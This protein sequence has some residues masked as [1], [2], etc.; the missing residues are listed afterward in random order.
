MGYLNICAILLCFGVSL[1]CCQNVPSL[2]W[3]FDPYSTDQWFKQKLDHYDAGSIQYWPQR[4]VTSYRFYRLGGPVF[5]YLSGPGPE[6]SV[7]DVESGAIAAYAEE[8]GAFVIGLEHRYYGKSKPTQDLSTD[9]LKYLTVPQTIEDIASFIRSW[10]ARSEFRNSKL[11]MFGASYLGSVT[12]WFAQKHPELLDAFVSSSAPLELRYEIPEF[13]QSIGTILNQTDP[14]CYETVQEGFSCLENV[15]SEQGCENYT[16]GDI[17]TK[18]DLCAELDTSNAVDVTGIFAELFS[19]VSAVVMYHNPDPTSFPD[20]NLGRFCK[21]ITAE[22]DKTALEKIGEKVKEINKNRGLSCSEFRFQTTV[23]FLDDKDW[24][25]PAA[26]EGYRQ[27]QFQL[28]NEL[29]WTV[30]SANISQ[31]FGHFLSPF[32]HS[33]VCKKLFGFTETEMRLKVLQANN[34]L[35]GKALST[36]CGIY[37]NGDHDPWHTFS[38][39]RQE[40]AG[41]CNRAILIQGGSHGRDIEEFADNPSYPSEVREAQLKIARYLDIWLKTGKCCEDTSESRNVISTHSRSTRAPNSME[42]YSSANDMLKPNVQIRPHAYPHENM[43]KMIAS[44]TSI[45]YQVSTTDVLSVS[46]RIPI[47]SQDQYENSDMF[48]DP[49]NIELRRYRVVKLLR[50]RPS[51][52]PPTYER[53][54][55]P[56]MEQFEAD[57]PE[58]RLRVEGRVERVFKNGTKIDGSTQTS[59]QI[60]S[61]RSDIESQ[62]PLEQERKLMVDETDAKEAQT[63]DSMNTNNEGGLQNNNHRFR[64]VVK[65]IFRNVEDVENTKEP[66][67]EEQ[68]TD[69]NVEDT[70]MEVKESQESDIGQKNAEVSLSPKQTTKRQQD[71]KNIDITILKQIVEKNKEDSSTSDTDSH[72]RSSEIKKRE[73]SEENNE[74][75]SGSTEENY[76][77]LGSESEENSSATLKPISSKKTSDE[78]SSDEIVVKVYTKP[79]VK[80]NSKSKVQEDTKEEENDDDYYEDDDYDDDDDE[81]EESNETDGSKEDVGRASSRKSRNDTTKSNSSTELSSGEDG[82]PRRLRE[83]ISEKIMSSSE[84]FEGAQK[85]KEKDSSSKKSKNE[86]QN[87]HK[88]DERTND[89]E[90]YEDLEASSSSSSESTSD[91]DYD[92]YSLE[93]SGSNTQ[94]VYRKKQLAPIAKAAIEQ[95]ATVINVEISGSY[96]RRTHRRKTKKITKIIDVSDEESKYTVAEKGTKKPRRIRIHRRKRPSKAK[97]VINEDPSTTEGLPS[98]TP[99]TTSTTSTSSTAA[100]ATS[101]EKT[102]P[103]EMPGSNNYAA[104]N[105]LHKQVV[106]SEAKPLQQEPPTII[107]LDTG[108]SV[109]QG[110]ESSPQ[111]QNN[112]GVTYIIIGDIPDENGN[113]IGEN[114]SNDA[115]F[116]FIQKLV[117]RHSAGIFS[118]Q[119]PSTN[120]LPAPVLPPPPPP[121]PPTTTTTTTQAPPHFQNGFQPAGKYL[122]VRPVQVVPL[123]REQVVHAHDLRNDSFVDF[124]TMETPHNNHPY[125]DLTPQRSYPYQTQSIKRQNS[126]QY[127]GYRFKSPFHREHFEKLLSVDGQ[128]RDIDRDADSRRVYQHNVRR[129]DQI[130]D[131]SW[132]SIRGISQFGPLPNTGTTGGLLSLTAADTRWVNEGV[133]FLPRNR[134]FRTAHRSGGFN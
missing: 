45:P 115:L 64:Y 27:L 10:K 22:N 123:G 12:A 107:N 15:I 34:D 21:H 120:Y 79:A 52:A 122:L 1:V 68:V 13:L 28:C 106:E 118:H 75:S 19:T 46:P 91:E 131:P 133:P 109:S 61:P 6:L 78:S 7:D 16:L 126:D 112:D 58:H 33:E 85:S 2:D 32:L 20:T 50:H 44:P 47:S 105:K 127:G 71:L 17:K 9:N 90:S 65:Q 98:T 101:I 134:Q 70:S 43:E 62:Q 130:P 81:D 87:R 40:E 110:F 121:P 77:L 128:V 5:I 49:R 102:F 24:D 14:K 57:F 83:K 4:Y 67:V 55:T 39:S 42:F 36:Q 116:D 88:E 51:F 99:T 56:S 89:N 18:F 74:K 11:V 95:P 53:S 124:M 132:R 125:Q 69:K 41:Q 60:Q 26:K 96:P 119:R 25:S 3:Q 86:K 35:K 100:D 103:N 30:A 8:Q 114:P 66:E 82:K 59:T 94:K 129:L 54:M 113:S 73:S 108:N 48:R 104:W 97:S 29:G 31:P 72:E 38:I 92:N 117:S 111:A 63:P 93:P 76:S 84:E 23:D 37:V 80:Q